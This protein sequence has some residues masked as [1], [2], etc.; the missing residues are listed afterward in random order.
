M[1]CKVAHELIVGKVFNDLKLHQK[2]QI[3]EV[4]PLFEDQSS[5]QAC[6][7]ILFRKI[8][9]Q[10]ISPNPVMS[11]SIYRYVKPQ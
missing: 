7:V 4:F 10:K 8:E 2:H 11:L 9:I 3:D 1:L 6:E 5:E